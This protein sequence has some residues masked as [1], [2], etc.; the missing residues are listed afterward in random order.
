[1]M[2]EFD[3]LNALVTFEVPPIVLLPVLPFDVTE[4]MVG[5]ATVVAW[6]LRYEMSLV[7]PCVLP[8]A[9]AMLVPLNPVIVESCDAVVANNCRREKTS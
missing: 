1:M 8:I 6:A 3:P 4:E 2:F 7:T 5:V 9:F